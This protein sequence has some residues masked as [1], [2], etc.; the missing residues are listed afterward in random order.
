VGFEFQQF[1]AAVRLTADPEEPKQL[2]GGATVVKFR[3]AFSGERRK[4]DGE[5][6]DFPVFMDCEAIQ[7][8]NGRKIVDEVTKWG[9]KGFKV[10]VAGTLKME[11]WE[12]K[13]GGGKRR[14]IKL[15]VTDFVPMEAVE[16]GAKPKAANPPGGNGGGGYQTDGADAGGYGDDDPIPF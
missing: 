14:A 13:N 4:V 9:R 5:W 6:T 16:K 2:S 15:K 12:D 3:V 8:E 7:F 11:E 1:Q 10:F